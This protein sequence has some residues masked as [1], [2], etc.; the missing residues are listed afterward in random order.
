MCQGAA[1]PALHQVCSIPEYAAHVRGCLA[2]RCTRSG[3]SA[4]SFRRANG[5]FSRHL[6]GVQDASA[7]SLT[8]APHASCAILNG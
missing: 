1:L 6:S 2:M 3:T 8:R 7:W 4:R 5:G